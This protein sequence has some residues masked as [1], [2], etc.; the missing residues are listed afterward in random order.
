MTQWLINPTSIHEDEDKGAALKDKRQKKKSSS[1]SSL[2]AQPLKDPGLSLQRLW[3]L[4]WLRFN[5][6]PGNFCMPWTW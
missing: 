4:L 5:L 2:V 1:Q 3:L 6:W